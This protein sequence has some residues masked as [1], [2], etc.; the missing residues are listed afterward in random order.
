MRKDGL[1]QKAYVPIP[2]GETY[3]P[4]VPASESVAEFTFKAVGLGI[5]FG[6]FMQGA[7]RNP[8]GKDRDESRLDRVGL[9]PPVPE[10]EYRRAEERAGQEGRWTANSDGGHAH[11]DVDEQ[12]GGR[13]ENETVVRTK[14]ANSRPGIDAPESQAHDADHDKQLVEDHGHEQ[15]Q[16]C[17]RVVLAETL[18]P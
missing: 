2:E 11:R 10:A 14:T 7:F 9:V 15:D 4:F 13:T 5:L 12:G 17:D 1:S 6:N 8:S 16:Q 18:P 3:D